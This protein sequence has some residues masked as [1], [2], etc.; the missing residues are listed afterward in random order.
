[1]RRTFLNALVATALGASAGV[2]A[3]AYPSQPVQMI[4]PFPAGSISDTVARIVSEKLGQRLGQPVLVQNRPGAGATLGSGEVARAKADGHTILFSGNSTLTINPFLYR[5]VPYDPQMDFQPL[6]MAGEIPT[7]LIAR[8]DL[9][10]ENMADLIKLAKERPGKFSIAHGS[11]TSNVAIQ[12]LKS[13]AGIDVAS[14]PYKGEPLGMTDVLGGHVD[15]MILNL[16]VAYQHILDG[17]VKAIALPG[18]RKVDALPSIPLVS[19]TLAGYT[20]PNGWLAMWVPG[21][22][23]APVA[24]RLHK[25]LVEILNASDVRARILATGGYLLYTT[26]PQELQARTDQDAARWAR[27]IKEARIELQ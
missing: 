13:V 19:E 25:E 27:M 24:H 9:G 1:M 15:L 12:M 26:T 18:N 5:K 23:P 10:V 17:R 14:V 21:A 2:L 11:A 7:V 6:T 8:K 16:P 4:V 3:Q 22:T 20:M